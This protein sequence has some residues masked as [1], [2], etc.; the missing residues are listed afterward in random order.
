MQAGCRPVRARDA[1]RPCPECGVG[2]SIAGGRC[3]ICRGKSTLGRYPRP[4]PE[5]VLG[6]LD[7]L[8]R[9]SGCWLWPGGLSGGYGHVTYRV[10]GKRHDAKLHILFYELFVEPV[11]PG[12]LLDHKCR[13]RPCCNPECLEPVTNQ[14]NVIRGVHGRHHEAMAAAGQ[15]RLKVAA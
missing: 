3:L 4:R 9:S 1:I 15:I 13:H 12:L 8:D 14:V 5:T 2:E 6:W 11:A 7:R 10:D